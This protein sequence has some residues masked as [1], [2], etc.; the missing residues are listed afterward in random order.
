[1]K[2]AVVGCGAM[3][4]VYAALFASAGHE[5]WAVDRWREHVEAIRAHGLRLEGASGDRTVRIGATT[6]ARE[7][8]TCDLVILATKA[9][10]VA[11]AA[12]AARPLLGPETP[13][14]SIQNGLGG[15]EAAAA[16]LGRE[17]VMVGVVGGFGASI[18]APGHA[19][20]NGMELVRLGELGG[21]SSARLAALEA[22]WREAGFRVRVYQDIGQLVWEKLVCNC[23]YSGPCALGEC[24]VG[25]AMADPDLARVS[26]ACASEAFE[27]AKAKGIRLDF[28]D[29]I[30]WV[31][32]FGSK[33]PNARPSV[34]LDLLARRRSEIGVI[35]GAIP[36]VA[37]E[38]GRE[39]PVNETVTALVL[40]KER[41]L[42]CT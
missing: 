15:P 11:E 18:R 5:V 40:A 13:V 20:H 16:A 27:T 10:H 17:R 14:L 35:N 30:A 32:E 25:E 29:P 31:R 19:H 41:R 33:I 22:L 24:T 6:D 28:S 3:G 39:A 36:R 34:L 26:A 38:L 12:A 2:I 4:S 7:P 23:A 37:R 21:G 1:M 9:M 42:G 8:G